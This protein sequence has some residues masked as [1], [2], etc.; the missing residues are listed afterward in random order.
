MKNYNENLRQKSTYNITSQLKHSKKLKAIIEI[1]SISYDK[2]V[3][4]YALL[5]N[6]CGY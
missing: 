1:V 2:N 3:I 4:L 6:S 5:A